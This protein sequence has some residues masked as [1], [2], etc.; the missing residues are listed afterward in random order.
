[1]ANKLE[2][3]LEEGADEGKRKKKK[4]KGNGFGGWASQNKNSII[5]EDEPGE[6]QPGGQVD[7]ETGEPLPVIIDPPSPDGLRR[8]KKKKVIIDPANGEAIQIKI[9]KLQKKAQRELDKKGKEVNSRYMQI[10]TTKQQQKQ[11]E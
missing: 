4:K 6:G 3:V 5:Y 2:D 9:Q 10:Q 11:H 1:M 8:K 7:P